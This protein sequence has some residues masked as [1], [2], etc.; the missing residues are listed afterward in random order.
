MESPYAGICSF[1]AAVLDGDIPWDF[2]RC[3]HNQKIVLTKYTGSFYRV[4]DDLSQSRHRYWSDSD[5]WCAKIDGRRS[6]RGFHCGGNA[7]CDEPALF[8]RLHQ[9][10]NNAI[11]TPF[12]S[13]YSSPYRAMKEAQRRRDQP[14]VYD[15]ELGVKVHRG[16]VRIATTYGMKCLRRAGV[17]I[18]ASRDLVKAG[19]LRRKDFP[20]VDQQE[21]LAIRKVPG[22][23]M[24]KD[25][26]LKD[27]RKW[28]FSRRARRVKSRR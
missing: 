19:I 15:K 7:Y 14:Y 28:F 12:I 21:W 11:P 13:L 23:C 18:F 16:R 10:W 22:K 9:D 8:A 1:C 5:Y 26:N 2:G 6:T 20:L 24:R 4:Y 3:G 25:R 27:F 17:D